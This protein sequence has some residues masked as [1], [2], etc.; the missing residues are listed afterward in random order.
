[1][2]NADPSGGNKEQFSNYLKEKT[3]KLLTALWGYVKSFVIAKPRGEHTLRQTKDYKVRMYVS[4][5]L[6]KV[7]SFYL[8][9]HVPLKK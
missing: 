4:Q 1:M 9:H 6:L 2:S 7:F 8:K 3:P 5:F